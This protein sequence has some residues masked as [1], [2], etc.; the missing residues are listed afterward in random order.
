MATCRKPAHTFRVLI[1]A[2]M[3]IA[4]SG[5]SADEQKSSS[6]GS[7]SPAR[8]TEVANVLSHVSGNIVEIAQTDS[9]QMAS[10]KILTGQARLKDANAYYQYHF[11]IDSGLYYGIA[12]YY[13]D[14]QPQPNQHIVLHGDPSKDY[15]ICNAKNQPPVCGGRP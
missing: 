12:A 8:H 2:L 4:I 5:C 10:G 7:S 13:E 11:T 6:S 1:F 9:V 15:T 3:V 14:D